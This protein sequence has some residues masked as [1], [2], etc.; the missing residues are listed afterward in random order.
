MLQTLIS[1]LCL[2]VM[3]GSEVQ[4][5]T[6]SQRDGG[7]LSSHVLDTSSGLPAAG[8]KMTFEKYTNNTWQHVLVK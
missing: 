2:L 1:S 3:Y 4:G 6:A 7:P 5:C 8:I